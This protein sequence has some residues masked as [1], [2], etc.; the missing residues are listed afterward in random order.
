[1]SEPLRED[2]VPETLPRG[3]NAA[4]KDVVRLSQRTR[5][6][7]AMTTL[8]AEKGYPNVT[9]ADLVAA[10]GVAKPTFYDHFSD[11]ENCLMVTL[12]E[13]VE[14]AGTE[15]GA[16]LSRDDTVEQRVTT[17]VKTLIKFLA[18]DDAR[19]RVLLIE[20]LKAGPAVAA[21]VTAAHMRMAELYVMWREESRAHQPGLPSISINRG[22]AIVGANL[23]PMTV[24][25]RS[26]SAERLVELTDELTIV[27]KALA[28]A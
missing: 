21:A 4:S 8:A 1:M 16:A 11:K 20:S 12:R 6:I 25:L 24:M 18:D 7:A 23:E 3:R 22:L 26:H 28:T 15:V 14:Q 19:A 2:A 5:L 13:I 9:I 17:G 10:A 27:T